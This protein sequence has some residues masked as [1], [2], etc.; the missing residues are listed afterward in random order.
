MSLFVPCEHIICYFYRFTL[1][2]N[3]CVIIP[4]LCIPVIC[5]YFISVIERTHILT[6][7]PQLVLLT[8]CPVQSSLLFPQ[9]P[10][11]C[12]VVVIILIIVFWRS[13][14][15]QFGAAQNIRLVSFMNILV[16]VYIVIFYNWFT[17]MAGLTRPRMQG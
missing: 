11:L 4:Q 6:A 13:H 7:C 1:I 14:L 12:A 9:I 3:G 15:Y 16:I 2:F 17:F 10:G 5:W 8:N